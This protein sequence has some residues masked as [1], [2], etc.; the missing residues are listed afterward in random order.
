MAIEGGRRLGMMPLSD[1][2]VGYVQSG[3]VDV[4]EAYRH[5]NDR[6]GFI[7]LLKRRGVDTSAVERVG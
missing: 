1:A 4:R 5:V 3:I 2:L 6:P 7:A